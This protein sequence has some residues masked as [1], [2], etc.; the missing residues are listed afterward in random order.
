MDRKI[1]L[2]I[3]ILFI[4]F[5]Q[6][7]ILLDY[8]R[9]ILSIALTIV[10]VWI[11]YDI[12]FIIST[13]STYKEKIK[14]N[15]NWCFSYN[16]IYKNN[17]SY[18]KEKKDYCYFPTYS[19]KK[20]E[21]SVALLLKPNTHVMVGDIENTKIVNERKTLKNNLG[22]QENTSV[23]TTK[24]ENDKIEPIALLPPPTSHDVKVD[25]NSIKMIHS[26][27]SIFIENIS[28]LSPI[29]KNIYDAIIDYLQKDCQ[30]IEDDILSI[31]SNFALIDVSTDGELVSIFCESED[32]VF[33]MYGM[34]NAIKNKIG[35]NYKVDFVKYNILTVF[36]YYTKNGNRTI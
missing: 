2:K 31:L 8:G 36:D 19:Y 7:I 30:L 25:K 26:E 13:S 3:I 32:V 11:I 18:N 21:E 12:F 9:H 6:N 10:M 14:E 23:E 17:Y 5:F 27:D 24:I 33:S 22:E 35:S 20:H 29:K 28:S 4:L 34:Q 16:N 15:D 1:S